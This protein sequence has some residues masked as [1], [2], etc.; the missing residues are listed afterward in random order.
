MLHP[1]LL[2]LSKVGMPAVWKSEYYVVKKKNL[3]LYIYIYDCA[4]WIKNRPVKANSLLVKGTRIICDARRSDLYSM[5]FWLR[6]CV[7]VCAW[8]WETCVIFHGHFALLYYVCQHRTAHWG[9]IYKMIYS[10]QRYPCW[11]HGD[12][13]WWARERSQISPPKV[14]VAH[15]DC[16][17]TFLLHSGIK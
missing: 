17:I 3:L 13:W 2:S 8:M 16:N 11:T 9:C 12:G 7:C 6:V 4:S 1:A 5:L 14:T 15:I 10:V